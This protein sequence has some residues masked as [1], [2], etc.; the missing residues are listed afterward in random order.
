MTVSITIPDKSRLFVKRRRYRFVRN[1]RHHPPEQPVSVICSQT[2]DQAGSY[3]QIKAISAVKEA[4]I[5]SQRDG[6]KR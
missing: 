6:A 3:W 1:P 5:A 4:R 2:P